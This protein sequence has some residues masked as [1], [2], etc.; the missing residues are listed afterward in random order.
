MNGDTWP[1]KS[2]ILL[3]TSK[4]STFLKEW[5][6]QKKKK[7]RCGLLYSISFPSEDKDDKLI[8][9]DISSLIIFLHIKM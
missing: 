2:E 4:S 6:K 8:R 3:I 7:K 5:D 9:Y 1:R